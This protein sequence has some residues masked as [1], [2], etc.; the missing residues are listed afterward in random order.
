MSYG[1]FARGT[2]GQMIIDDTHTTCHVLRKGSFT[3]PAGDTSG[4][5][6]YIYYSAP[7]TTLSSPQVWISIVGGIINFS[8][9]GTPGNWTG[10]SYV[11]IN[12]RNAITF[13]YVASTY[14]PP[15]SGQQWGLKIWNDS[16]KPVFD[17]GYAGMIFLYA[18]RKY[19]R[20]DMGGSGRSHNYQWD[21]I[22]PYSVNPNAYFLASSTCLPIYDV[23]QGN[24]VGIA[25][26]TAY[27]TR[28]GYY[29]NIF[30]YNSTPNPELWFPVIYAIPSDEM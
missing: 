7:I 25:Y 1:F 9:E 27:P 14:E 3:V 28:A 5:V 19:R 2:N 30:Q 29:I 21:T 20:T 16:G 18:T 10:F 11:S 15:S 12:N 26:F 4:N 22:D 17:S 24:G 8:H 13:K 23:G 6:N